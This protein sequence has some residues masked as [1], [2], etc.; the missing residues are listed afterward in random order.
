MSLPLQ[1]IACR[2]IS[3]MTYTGWVGR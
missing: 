2:I 1:V 3:E